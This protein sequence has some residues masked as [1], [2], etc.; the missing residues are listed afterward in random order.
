M[1]KAKTQ[2]IFNKHQLKNIQN[3]FL[4]KSN[5]PTKYG[6]NF[7]HHNEFMSN[8]TTLQCSMPFQT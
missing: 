7:K 8:S 4:L 5:E 1:L 3:I 2:L 6:E